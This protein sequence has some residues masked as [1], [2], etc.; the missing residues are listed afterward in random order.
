MLL[1]GLTGPS[2]AGKGLFCHVMRERYGIRSIDADEVYHTLI[3]PP[4]PCLD[5][6]TE[7][8]GR[9]ILSES[10]A[11][12]RKALA[13]IVFS[14]EDG[15]ERERRISLLNSVTHRFVLE[16]TRELLRAAEEGGA[17][18]MILDAPALYESGADA[19]CDLIVAV[20]ADRDTRVDRITE[21]DHIT[22]DA[23]SLRV[24][25]QHP[26]AFYER[27]ATAIL[28]NDGSPR[29]FEAAVTAFYGAHVLPRLG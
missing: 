16:R 18:A 13:G 19:W 29:E 27:R 2:G 17:S 4:S 25:G 7:A 23:A 8:F 24:R 10:G 20:T 1:I 5:A 28:H 15:A 9:E 21:R 11:L 12:D 22:R 6:L 14:P 3:T 26:D